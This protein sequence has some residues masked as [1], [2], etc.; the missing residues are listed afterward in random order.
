MNAGYDIIN[1]LSKTVLVL[2][3]V[4]MLKS[5][6]KVNVSMVFD[7]N[8]SFKNLCNILPVFHIE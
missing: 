2:G 4:E 5:V 8:K 3:C 7:V 1:L 6:K